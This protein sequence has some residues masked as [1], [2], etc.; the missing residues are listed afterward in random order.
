MRGHTIHRLPVC[1]NR[2]LTLHAPAVW[3]AALDGFVNRRLP[4]AAALDLQRE[5]LDHRVI[6]GE[7]VPDSRRL[8]R[9]EKLETGSVVA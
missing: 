7:T 9:G 6:V 3:S 2:L 4:T 5:A 8:S 1:A